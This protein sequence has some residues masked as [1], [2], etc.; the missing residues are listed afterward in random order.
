MW[1]ACK[2]KECTQGFVVKH[3]GKV[4]IGSLMHRCEDNIKMD[5]RER[6]W[7]DVNWILLT[8]VEMYVGLL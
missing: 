1:H 4:Q 6:G 7:E 3:E 5:V 2:L 8:K